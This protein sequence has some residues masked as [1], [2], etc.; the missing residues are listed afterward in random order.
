MFTPSAKE[1]IK[2]K[3]LITFF[4]TS[5][6]NITPPMPREHRMKVRKVLT[7]FVPAPLWRG[8]KEARRVA[9]ERRK[10]LAIQAKYS[11]NKGL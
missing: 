2:S 3:H 9:T 6:C 4:N 8:G 5:I 1:N 7:A 10:T 11:T